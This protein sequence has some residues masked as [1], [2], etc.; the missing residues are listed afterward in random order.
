[1]P[2]LMV[3]NKKRTV[4]GLRLLRAFL[5]LVIIMTETAIGSLTIRACRNTTPPDQ[6][7][8]VGCGWADTS[9]HTPQAARLQREFGLFLR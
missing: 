3:Q 9:L 1:M 5:L 6:R 4:A 2:S 8:Q 7:A